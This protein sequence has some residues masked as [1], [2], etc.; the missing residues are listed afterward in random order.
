MSFCYALKALLNQ[1][2]MNKI[3]N[4]SIGPLHGIMAD[5]V[6]DTSNKEQLDLVFRYTIGKNVVERLYEYVDRKSITG[7]SVC[8]GIVSILESAQLLV[9][10][11]RAQTYDCA[12]NIWSTKRLRGTF[13]AA[14]SQSTVFS[15]CFS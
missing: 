4:Q 8:R 6:T 1:K 5:E 10:D 14:C 11:C 3:K 12:G 9:S 13:S 15:L 7:E 2:V